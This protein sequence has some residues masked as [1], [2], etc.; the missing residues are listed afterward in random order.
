M[1]SLTDDFRAEA[2]S[3]EVFDVPQ[4]LPLNVANFAVDSKHCDG[5]AQISQTK[6][7]TTLT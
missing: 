1:Y 2:H 4:L 6:P 3:L 5:P 7:S